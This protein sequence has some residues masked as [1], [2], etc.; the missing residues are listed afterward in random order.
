MEIHKGKSHRPAA[1]F[2]MVRLLDKTASPMEADR[3]PEMPVSQRTDVHGKSSGGISMLHENYYLEKEKQD[4]L[5][6]RKNEKSVFYNGIYDRY[7]YP[8]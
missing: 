3:G 1:G 7:L 6:T 4:R 8:V 5:L 2:G